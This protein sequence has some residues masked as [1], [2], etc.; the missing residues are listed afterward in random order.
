MACFCTRAAYQRDIP[1]VAGKLR[2]AEGIRL[3][4]AHVLHYRQLH[5]RAIT[6]ARSLRETFCQRPRELDVDGWDTHDAWPLG[7]RR[8]LWF[9]R[10]SANLIR[11]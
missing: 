3:V 11:G 2:D 5:E 9:S 4:L 1:G 7:N 8:L 10:N 6:R